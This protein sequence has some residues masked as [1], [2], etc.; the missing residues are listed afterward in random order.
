[1]QGR[2]VSQRKSRL[3]CELAYYSAH[4]NAPRG[5]MQNN[6]ALTL[7]NDVRV[8]IHRIRHREP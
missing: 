1:M 3:P 2:S 4:R 8:Q 7:K 5:D 6:A